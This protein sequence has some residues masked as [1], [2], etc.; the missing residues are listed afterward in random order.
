MIHH[1]KLIRDTCNNLPLKIVKTSMDNIETKVFRKVNCLPPHWS[2]KTPKRYKRNAINID[3]HRAK[4]IS[5]DFEAETQI[6]IKKFLQ[7]GY[8]RRF[9][10]SAINSFNNETGDD[11]I[12]IPDWLFDPKPRITIFLPYSPKN[13]HFAKP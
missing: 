13:E 2:S 4:A 6:I 7:A 11:D 12:L 8:P 5:S 9:I 3:L 10:L 1:D